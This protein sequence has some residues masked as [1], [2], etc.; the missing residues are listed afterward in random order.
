MISVQATPA[1]L[2][3]MNE[4]ILPWN[5]W[6]RESH[7]AC[8]NSEKVH[9]ALCP[10]CMC[11][12]V[13]VCLFVCLH[14]C[15]FAIECMCVC[16]SFC[17]SA[18]PCERYQGLPIRTQTLS[19]LSYEGFKPRQETACAFSPFTGQ[20]SE[21]IESGWNSG[22]AALCFSFDSAVSSSIFLGEKG[23]NLS[24]ND[25][26]K[27]EFRLNGLKSSEFSSAAVCGDSGNRYPSHLKVNWRTEIL[28]KGKNSQ[29]VSFRCF[30]AQ[31]LERPSPSRQIL[32]RIP[33]GLHCVFLFDRVVSSSFSFGEKRDN[34]NLF[35]VSTL[36]IEASGVKSH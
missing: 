12:C 35:F 32:V 11:V 13:H 28:V 5:A 22:G 17:L 34:L 26:D 2:D 4:E 8:L 30:V 27:S 14:L 24:W 19:P 6:N 29:A 33:L 36:W 16:V 3:R 15:V 23:E 7:F 18:S 25:P 10:K 9:C 1:G 31:W 20:W 21:S